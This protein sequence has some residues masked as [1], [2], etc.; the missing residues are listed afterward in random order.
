VQSIH[1]FSCRFVESQ[2]NL[3]GHW[4]FK[5]E[6]CR[7]LDAIRVRLQDILPN[8]VTNTDDVLAQAD[9]VLGLGTQVSPDGS[10][11]TS[12]II[13]APPLLHGDVWE[14]ALLNFYAAPDPPKTLDEFLKAHQLLRVKAVTAWGH[15]AIYLELAAADKRRFELW[16][17][18]QFNYLVRKF[19]IHAW[20]KG[21]EERGEYEVATFR[22]VA[23]GIYFPERINMRWFSSGEQPAGSGVRAFTDIRVN[24]PLPADS[25]EFRFPAGVEVLDTIQSKMFKVDADGNLHEMKDR[26]VGGIPQGSDRLDPPTDQPDQPTRVISEEAGSGRTLLL[27]VGLLVLWLIING[28]FLLR[29]KKAGPGTT[30][31]TQ[32]A[33]EPGD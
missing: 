6:Y 28:W 23:P 11:R 27:M 15:E 19:V 10:R 20:L 18:P 16:L 32:G 8:K 25:F 7:S 2:D 21:K 31:S 14:K 29:R 22:E 17:D 12:G 4:E 13:R 9:R 3:E 1:T 5:A 33:G 24:E 30:S 26:R